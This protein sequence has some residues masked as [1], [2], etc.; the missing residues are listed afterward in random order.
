MVDERKGSPWEV[1][2][3][4][5]II[6][7]SFGSTVLLP[8][9]ISRVLFYIA[10]LFGYLIL[11]KKGTLRFDSLNKYFYLYCL[12]TIFS[13]L[14]SP[15]FNIS[16]VLSTFQLILITIL[17]INI[18]IA[19][20]TKII[21]SIMKVLSILVYFG[22]AYSFIL[23]TFGGMMNY[24]DEY[25]NYLFTPLI[26]QSVIGLIGD[27]GYCSLWRN[28]NS[29]GFYILFVFI[30]K[31]CEKSDSTL[32]T[33]FVEVYLILGSFLANSRAIYICLFF[34][35]VVYFYLKLEKISKAV[36]LF[37]VSIFLT[38][39]LTSGFLIDFIADID[40]MGREGMWEKMFESIKAY[41]IF[42]I[43]FTATSKYLLG[44][45]DSSYA[46]GSHNGYLNIMAEIGLVGFFIFLTIVLL[47]FQSIRKVRLID[48]KNIDSI[49]NG[50]FLYCVILFVVY[51]VYSVVENT[52]MM[53]DSKNYIWI[54]ICIYM[55]HVGTGYGQREKKRL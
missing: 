53:V 47:V 1:V 43:G 23:K 19:D 35:I 50:M 18:E 24:D 42:G 30:W 21:A 3:L 48:K 10:L 17:L 28:P 2:E 14:L 11:L 6:S 49:D 46:V 40:L 29:F 8:N 44:D 9:V 34:A 12:V 22:I 38:I 41:P 7:I 37:V 54:M 32:K 55:Y 27:L 13:M 31:L 25:I 4:L 45:I 36:L 20:V 5:L 39:G 51:L 15:Y 16:L 33:F 52:F 26:R